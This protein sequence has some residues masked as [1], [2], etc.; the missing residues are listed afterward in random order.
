MRPKVSVV[1]PCYQ[2]EETLDRALKSVVGQSVQD[3]EVV[4]VNDGS[5]DAT[6]QILDAWAKRDERIRVIHQENA[7]VSM[8]RNAG[9]AAARGEWLFFLDGDDHLPKEALRT[10]LEMPEADIVCGAYVIRHNGREEVHRCAQGSRKT[11]Y[12]SLIR[13]DSALNSMCARLYRADRL[14][15]KGILAPAGIGIGEDVL[16]N[17]HAFSAAESWQMTDEIVYYYELGGDSAMMRVRKDR[18][19]KSRPMI[20]GILDFIRENGLET[21]LYRALVDLYVRT[22]R[23]DYG[24]IGAGLHLS[25]GAVHEFSRG[26]R[27]DGLSAKQKL[28]YIALNLVPAASML[29]P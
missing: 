25:Y 4:A 23:L 11:V 16:F 10:L 1:M 12:E 29:L 21:E 3:L 9:M 26:V 13:G 7:G 20:L 6:G 8:A 18:Y 14:K 24:R 22:L 27:F 2:N 19:L 17:L 28:Y 5:R 15:K